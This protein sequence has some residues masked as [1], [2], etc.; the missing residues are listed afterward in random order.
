MGR[1]GARAPVPVICIGNF[2]AGGAGK[3]PT[4]LA[5]AA[6]LSARG[7]RPAFLSRGYGG[8]LAGPVLVDP[9]RHTARDVGDEPLLLVRAAPAILARD[10]PAGAALAAERG[11]SVVIMDDGLQ[12]PSLAKDLA[13]AVVDGATGIGNGLTLPA[14]P[15]RA[16]M[17]AQWAAIDAVLV[18]G[19][20]EPGSRVAEEAAR[21]GKPV[22]RGRLAPDQNA[23]AALA[24]ARVVAFAGIGRPE[25]FFETLRECGA[26]PVAEHSFPDHHLYRAA[27]IAALA[28]EATAGGLRLVTTE[29]DRVR[30]ET[31]GVPVA[32][33]LSLPVRLVLDDES[34]LEALL[35]RALARSPRT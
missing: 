24:G 3:T 25:K 16:P 15:L 28:A 32:G 29:K 2:T 8:R 23:A 13:L 27:E 1:A 34:A 9:H 11:A 5:V 19:K 7:E 10:R 35:A 6:L 22:L 33:L 12:N 31:L 17:P 4:A 18:I 26:V 14:G 21:R 30:I 20:G